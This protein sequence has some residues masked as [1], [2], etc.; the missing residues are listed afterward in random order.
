MN[1]AHAETTPWSP[2]RTVRGGVIR[3]KNLLDGREGTPTNFSLVLADTDVTFKSP[4]HRHN[5]D[6]IRI[7][8]EGSTNYGPRENIDVDDVVY[9]PEG[10]YYGPQDQ[11]L[12]KASSLAMVIQFGGAS[13]SGYMSQRQLF[14]GQ[15]KLKAFGRFEGGVYKRND[16]APQERRNQ[17]A[18]EAVWEFQHGRPV[19]YPKPRLTQPVHFRAGNVPWQPLA[20]HAGVHLRELG[21]F[22]ERDIHL[23][24]L[25][26]EA[27]ATYA[28]PQVGQERLLFV[29]RG[30]GRFGGGGE[31][32]KHSAAHLQ[33]DETCEL[34]A[35]EATEL[36]VLTL[37]RF[38]AGQ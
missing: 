6:Q 35:Q 27:G 38:E 22:S 15:E 36:L 29:L 32:L 21:R 26:L 9:F 1:I 12:V 30:S 10:T 34:Q 7:T 4:R 11:E 31:W 8:L 13:G 3:F 33:A 18:F 2:V 20:D 23:Y 28:M 14:E 17:D 25:K 37:P 5:F 19:E 24:T 16:P